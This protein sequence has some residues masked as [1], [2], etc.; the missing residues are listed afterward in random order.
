MPLILKHNE[1]IKIISGFYAGVHRVILDE[2]LIHQTVLVKLDPIEISQERKRGRP[3]TIE[4]NQVQFNYKKINTELNWIHRDEISALYESDLLIRINIEPEVVFLTP[5]KSNKESSLLNKRVEAM[6]DFLGYE[7]LRIRLLN[8]FGWGG[9]VKKAVNN[10]GYK[11]TQIYKLISLLCKHGFSENSLRTR[12]DKCGGFG[13]PRPCDGTRKKAGRKSAFDK[14]I[15]VNGVP[16]PQQPGIST[17][18]TNRVLAAYSTIPKPNPNMSQMYKTIINSSF[19]QKVKIENGVFVNIKPTIGSYPNLSQVRRIIQK[20]I[21]KTLLLQNKTTKNHYA[22]NVRGMIGKAIEGVSGPGHTWA[23]DSTVGDIYLCSAINRSWPVGRPIIYVIVDVW[24]T[25]VV[26]FYVCLTGPSWDMA[27][28]SLFCSLFDPKKIAEIWGYE[29]VPVLSQAPSMPYTVLSDRGENLS[30]AAKDTAYELKMSDSFTP[31]YRGQLKGG[32]EVQHRLIKDEQ[33]VFV[34]GAIDARKKELE[35]RQ[36]KYQDATLTVREYTQ[37]L[38][39]HYTEYNTT[40]DRSDRL[41]AH[42]KA[43]NV[44][45]TPAGLWEYGHNVGIGTNRETS[46]S[47]LI[48]HLLPTAKAT[49]N[50]TGISFMSKEYKTT[51]ELDEELATLAKRFG[52]N[53]IDAYYFPGSISKIWIQNFNGNG[54]LE[55]N[56]SDYANASQELTFDEVADAHEYSLIQKAELK[57]SM[58]MKKL[59]FQEKKDEIVNNAKRLTKDAKENNLKAPPPIN[60]SRNMESNSN[61]ILQDKQQNNTDSHLTTEESPSTSHHLNVMKLILDNMQPGASHD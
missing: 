45:P 25:I 30:K 16:S 31:P 48:T 59:E 40:A 9:L 33:F 36:V 50:R 4:S 54:M 14:L 42:M 23:I 20:Y 26:G 8:D 1:V 24:S 51:P 39:V 7:M 13:K 47:E 29:Y 12:F 41:D 32:V 55:L 43:C 46:Q 22:N 15:A 44:T 27:K 35:L 34:P 53:E 38:Q 37:L 49:I 17:D 61:V 18:W 60:L 52:K 28:I 2:P 5:P 3:K 19:V 11:T 21:S 56:I 57:H 58:L 10:S 6:K